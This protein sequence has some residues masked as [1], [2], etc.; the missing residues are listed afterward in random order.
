MFDDDQLVLVGLK[1]GVKGYLFK[2]VILEQL[3]GVI[4][5]VVDGGLLV[6]LVVIQC[7]LFGLEYMCNEFVSLDW[8]DLLMDCEIEI[9]WLMVSGF[10]NKEIVNLLGVV[11]GIIK[12]YVFNILFKLGVCDCIWVVLKVFEF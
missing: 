10:F 5:I 3:V 7:L 9:L 12:N 8:F 2:D 1:V 4:W 11:E 6:Q